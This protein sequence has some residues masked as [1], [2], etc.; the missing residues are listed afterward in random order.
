M[1]ILAN[2]I[3]TVGSL[4]LATLQAEISQ[5]HFPPNRRFVL[6]ILVEPHLLCV[7][8]GW[9]FIGSTWSC[10]R[11]VTFRILVSSSLVGSRRLHCSDLEAARE[12]STLVVVLV[13]H[14]PHSASAAHDGDFVVVVVHGSPM[15]RNEGFFCS[16][17]GVVNAWSSVCCSREAFSFKRLQRCCCLLRFCCQCHASS[18]VCALHFVDASLNGVR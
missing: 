1:P 8:N 16:S 15:S 14:P 11:L 18:K 17:L 9:F 3:G 12:S 2:N 13:L 4:V 6:Y 5:Q 7:W 10:F